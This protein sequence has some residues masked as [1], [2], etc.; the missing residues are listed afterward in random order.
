MHSGSERE[1]YLR[2]QRVFLHVEPTGLLHEIFSS[3]TLDSFKLLEIHCLQEPVFLTDEAK[4]HG[5]NYLVS[6]FVQ[7][8]PVTK[9]SIL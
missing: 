5:Q 9:D 7:Q 6:L 2:P 4:S 8:V 1:L 3:V